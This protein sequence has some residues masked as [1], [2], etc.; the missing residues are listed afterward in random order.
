ME[1][2]LDINNGVNK[3]ISENTSKSD[4]KEK[5]EPIRKRYKKWKQSK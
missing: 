3:E 5:K 1:E 2:N 4:S